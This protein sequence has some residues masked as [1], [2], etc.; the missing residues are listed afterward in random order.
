[1]NPMLAMALMALAE[2]AL[3]YGLSQQYARRM[4]QFKELDYSR[5]YPEYDRMKSLMAQNALNQL[6]QVSRG[7]ESR[8]SSRGLSMSPGIAQSYYAQYQSQAIPRLQGEMANLDIQQRKE[9]LRKFQMALQRYY[10]QLEKYNQKW[11]LYFQSLSPLGI[12]PQMFAMKAMG[13][14]S[15]PTNNT[16]V[17]NETMVGGGFGLPDLYY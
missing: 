16:G 15:K 2:T 11:N 13:Y 5:I 7:L 1:M 9:E 12:I 8:L 10:N 14:G 17:R 3:K 6:S 4:P